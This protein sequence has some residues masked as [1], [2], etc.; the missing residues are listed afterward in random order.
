[1]KPE[2]SAYE[3]ADKAVEVILSKK[4]DV[5]ILNFANCDMVGHT[6]IL[7]AAKKAVKAV[8]ECVERVLNAIKQV[9]GQALITADHG[10]ADYMFDPVT[11]EPFTAHTT[12]PVPLIKVDDKTNVKLADGGK[13]CDIAPTMLEMMGI[14]IPNEMSGHSLLKK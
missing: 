9:G 2:M 11:K 1:M 13:L 10:N 7:D 6:G 14:E 5:M 8:D 12:N 3:V 4:Y